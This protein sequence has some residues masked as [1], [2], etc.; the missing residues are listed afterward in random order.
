M[1]SAGSKI[2]E[3]ESTKAK[4]HPRILEGQDTERRARSR[5]PGRCYSA[6]SIATGV[7]S[8]AQWLLLSRSDPLD[9]NAFS[10]GSGAFA[11]RG[12]TRISQ[13]IVAL[14]DRG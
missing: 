10:I 14:P 3:R 8:F 13:G 11:S 12:G 2:A 6:E 1:Q 5:L 9:G 4:E 7:I